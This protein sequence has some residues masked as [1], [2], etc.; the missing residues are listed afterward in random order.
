[1]WADGIR[2]QD[3][4][5]IDAKYVTSPDAD[6]CQSLY[7]IGNVPAIVYRKALASQEYEM[8]RYWSAIEDPR[9]RVTHLE[10]IT[11]DTRAAEYFSALRKLDAVPG[12]V[13]IVL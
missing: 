1:M 5:A 9:N 8:L 3:G 7:N 13:R 4:A 12:Q 10:V 11:N 2:E 6:R